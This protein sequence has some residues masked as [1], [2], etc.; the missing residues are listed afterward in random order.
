MA[1]TEPL[2]HWPQPLMEY[3]GFMASF[4]ASGAVGFRYAALRRLGAATDDE[5]HVR[6]EAAQ[7]AVI[8]GLAGVIVSAVILATRLPEM[9]ERRH[10]TILQLVDGQPPLALQIALLLIALGGF[11]RA[12]TGRRGGWPLAG[13][14]VVAGALRPVFF[15]QWAR[16]VNPI[17]V[18]A[19][20]MWIGTL[21]VLVAVGLATILR[22]PLAPERRGT[23]AA[24]MVNGFSPLALVSAAVLAIFGAI[25]AW[26]HLKHLSALWTTPYGYAL[27][28]KLC[29]VLA[30]VALGV[31]NWRRQKPR[32][33]TEAGA[34]ALRGSARAELI[35]AAVVLAVTAVLVSLPSPK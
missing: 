3:A 32:M 4:L 30:V 28:T 13:V 18:L 17:H 15:G 14:G 10:L 26:T 11:A 21:F 2:I 24:E 5:R 9:A 16:A 29:V 7:L 35:V 22:S 8:L 25:T 33:G 1:A 23:L 20:G 12:F 31:W 19:G 6:K 27:I 34:L